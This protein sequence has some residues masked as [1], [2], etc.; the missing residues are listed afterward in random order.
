MAE[1]TT[2]IL[3]KPDCVSKN[4]CGEV[5]KRFEGAGFQ[6]RG[7]KMLQLDDAVLA[8]HYSHIASKPFFPDVADFM[9]KTPVV[10][11]ALAGENVIEQVRALLGPTD[12]RKAD[13]GTIRGDFGGDMMVNVAHASDSPEAA[14]AEL[15][16]FFKDGEIF[17]YTKLTA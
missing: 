14:A 9:K 4:L 1:Q 5:L 7:L 13:K 15:Q 16:R 3:L 10:A 12:S 11:L 6:I 8:D 17:S 2:L